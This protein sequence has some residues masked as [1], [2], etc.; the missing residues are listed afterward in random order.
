VI[1]AG[2]ISYGSTATPYGLLP[3]VTVAATVRASEQDVGECLA[4]GLAGQP[5]VVDDREG[6]RSLVGDVDRAGG[7]G[8]VERVGLR[9]AMLTV[10][11]M[12]WVWVLI[13][14]MLP[15]PRTTT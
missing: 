1:R 15:G 3:T 7:D 6:A 5:R 4:H 13:A 8:D 12:R 10:P 14:D 9:G 11:E 2:V